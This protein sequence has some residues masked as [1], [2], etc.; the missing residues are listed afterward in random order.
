MEVPKNLC[1]TKFFI[2]SLGGVFKLMKIGI[3]FIVIA[4]LVAK[5]F[6][7]KRTCAPQRGAK[8]QKM[9]YLCKY[10]V[11]RVKILQG[12]C[13]A[14]TMRCD[15]GYDVTIATYLLPDLYLPKMKNAL[16]VAWESDR[17]SCA[18]AVWYSYLLTHT[19]WTLGANNTSWRRETLILPFRWRGPA[20]HC[21]AM[22]MSQW[23]HNETLWWV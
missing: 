22:E 7:I 14:R 10:L 8:S 1:D 21:V 4:F 20:A 6:N 13:T 5:L 18:C 23:T 2:T 16:F 12:W 19:E 9:K 3:Y 15:S 11:Y 17:L